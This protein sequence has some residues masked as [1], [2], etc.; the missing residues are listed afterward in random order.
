MSSDERPA[1]AEVA[2][3]VAQ[4]RDLGVARAEVWYEHGSPLSWWYRVV[5]EGPAR[6][7]TDELQAALTGATDVAYGVADPEFEEE[8]DTGRVELDVDAGIVR[9]SIDRWV[10]VVRR[11]AFRLP[12]DGDADEA[13]AGADEVDR[14]ER[15]TDGDHWD[16]E[17]DA[18][19]RHS[20][21]AELART[22]T[23]IARLK[24]EDPEEAAMMERV[25]ELTQAVAEM[26]PDAPEDD[27]EDDDEDE[28]DEDDEDWI[29]GV[30]AEAITSLRAAGVRRA[31][32]TAR[33][34][35]LMMELFAKQSELDPSAVEV[36]DDSLKGVLEQSLALAGETIERLDA[37][38]PWE[39]GD[40][41]VDGSAPPPGS[42]LVETIGRLVAAVLEWEVG[43]WEHSRGSSATVE[44]DVEA[45]VV[46]G[47]H[48]REGWEPDEPLQV[49]LRVDGSP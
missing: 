46:T 7:V 17:W 36:A 12:L 29:A 41:S 44:I 15:D 11:E 35:H 8:S 45:G 34:R 33:G 18:L 2:A 6:E 22:K 48:V 43:D 40:I 3:H 10:A 19:S 37:E 27:D 31:S 16:A 30:V 14:P 47:E 42:E 49:E 1:A 38:G 32:A 21:A 24:D 25:L 20:N 23:E 13:E 28:D 9:V 5:F 26:F 39:I 4:L